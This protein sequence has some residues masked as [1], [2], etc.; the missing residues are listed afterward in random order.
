GRSDFFS[1]LGSFGSGWSFLSDLYGDRSG[2]LGCWCLYGCF[3][4]F[5]LG[6]CGLGCGLFLGIQGSG[7][8]ARCFVSNVGVGIAFFVGLFVLGYGVGVRVATTTT[9]TTTATFAFWIQSAVL[10]VFVGFGI[11]VVAGI[12]AVGLSQLF[13]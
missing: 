10:A 6:C 7:V 8:E 1:L 9:A 11:R 12:S 5:R 4:L 3:G 2:L 13:G